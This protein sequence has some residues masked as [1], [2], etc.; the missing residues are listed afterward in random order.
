MRKAHLLVISA[1][2]LVGALFS[3]YLCYDCD[4]VCHNW[5]SL[6]THVCHPASGTVCTHSA[7]VHMT[8]QEI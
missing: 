4:T 3:D 5:D 1:T 8:V 6:H 7:Y 2:H